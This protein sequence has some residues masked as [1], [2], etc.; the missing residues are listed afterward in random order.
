MAHILIVDDSGLARRLLRAILESGGH[1]VTEADNGAM[2][3]EQY[4]LYKPDL[5]MLDLLMAGMSG[6]DTLH[7]LRTMDPQARIIVATA[8]IQSSTRR[9][10]DE[11]GA[12]NLV[13]KPFDQET[14]LEIV[15]TTLSRGTP[16][17]SH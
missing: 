13:Q 7:Q 5:V 3:I 12:G 8:D 14:I 10:V 15:K 1:T 2:A 16:D 6:L 11:A 4:Y 17:E 9:L